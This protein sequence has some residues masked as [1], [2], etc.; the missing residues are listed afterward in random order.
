MK[1][2]MLVL[3]TLLVSPVAMAVQSRMSVQVTYDWSGWGSVSERWVIRRDAYGLTTRVQVVDAPDVQPRLPELL[4][5]GALSAFE[6]ALRA[7]PLTRDATVDLITSQLDRPAILKL[8]PELRSMPLARCS[9]AK[10]QAWARQALAGRGLQERVAE[11]FNGLR[12]DDYPFMTVVVSRLGHPDTVLVST[13]QHTMM[14]P[15]KR[16]S[17]A[18]F[19]Q[20]VLEGAQEEWRP[21]LSDALMG[22]LPAGEPTRERFK[23]AWFQN[24]L[25]GDLALE[26]LRCGTLRKET[27]D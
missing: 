27:A 8:D 1:A 17:S 23:I 3:A 7:A 22:L 24:R 2:W 18:D 15:W 26:A 11:H 9:F 19:D 4:P 14:L 6:A 25:R 20:Q 21:A 13:S 12:T 5:F 10:Q 16:L